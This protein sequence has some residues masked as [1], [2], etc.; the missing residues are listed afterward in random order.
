MGELVRKK[1]VGRGL[2]LAGA[3]VVSLLAQAC[4]APGGGGGGPAGPTTTTTTSTTLPMITPTYP[5]YDF[6]GL[7]MNCIANVNGSFY[8]F[9][10][11]PAS[12]AIKA[13]D[14]VTQGS[15]FDI[16]VVPGSFTPPTTVDTGGAGIYTVVNVNS[17][18]IRFLM[19]ENVTFV[20]SVMTA[21]INM[22]PG[23]PSLSIDTFQT[24]D[25]LVYRVPG[26]FV[27]GVPVNLPGVR[28]T[29]NAS[30][31]PGSAVQTAYNILGNVAQFDAG[32]VGIGCYP[33]VANQSFTT[34]FITAAP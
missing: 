34:T 21:G 7:N 2:V 28:L 32:I 27:P 33:V 18:E 8:P 23:Y 17:F 30:G 26:P 15:N 24:P 10:Q 13:P 31:A 1:Y 20:D 5:D 14:T 22:G 29:F 16:Y 19:P 6:F 4:A 12:V 25:H 11:P 3:V 9:D